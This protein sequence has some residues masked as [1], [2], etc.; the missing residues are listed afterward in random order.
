[1][2]TL[3]TDIPVRTAIADP[4]LDPPGERV[5]SAGLRAGPHPESSFVVPNANS[6]RLVL[7]TRTAPAFF[8]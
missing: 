4:P 8:R 1:V 5:G 3:A 7:P 2:P 6:W